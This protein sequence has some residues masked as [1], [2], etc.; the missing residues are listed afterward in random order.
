MLA[1]FS[2]FDTV[3]AELYAGVYGDVFSKVWP[4]SNPLKYICIFYKSVYLHVFY[5]ICFG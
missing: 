5:S 1:K 4:K 2:K 3:F